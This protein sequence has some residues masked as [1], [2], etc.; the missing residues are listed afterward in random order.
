M[1]QGAGVNLQPPQRHPGLLPPRNPLGHSN[2][3]LNLL[4]A[5]AA[6]PAANS[7]TLCRG[8][9]GGRGTWCGTPLLRPLGSSLPA[10]PCS[11]LVTGV[12]NME[13]AVTP[14]AGCVQQR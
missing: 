13:T 10:L 8:E 12:Q 5:A 7:R 1:Q 6:F 2:R 14:P 3:F 4:V 11:K 9:R